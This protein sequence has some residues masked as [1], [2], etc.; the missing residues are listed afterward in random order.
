MGF[1][2]FYFRFS[3]NFNFMFREFVWSVG[4][5]GEVERFLWSYLNRNRKM[6]CTKEI[7]LRLL[8]VKV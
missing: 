7:L 8:V 3:F 4:V 6:G 2:R 5:V 1:L